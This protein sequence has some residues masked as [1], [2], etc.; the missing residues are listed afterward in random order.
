MKLGADFFKQDAL[1][2]APALLGKTIGRRLKDGQLIYGKITETEVYRGEVDTA[3]HARV[4]KT[5]RTKTLYDEGGV[6]YIYL[7]YG[8]HYLL[9]IVT[10]K[11]EEP[12][13]V[14]IRAIATANGPGKLTKALQIDL[15]MNGIQ[16]TNSDLI[17]ILD[18]NEQASYKTAPRIGIDYASEPYKSIKWRFIIDE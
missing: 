7:C 10:G 13:A 11:K 17:W 14:L 4:G 2:V 8:V 16:I 3:C 9:N 6:I 5:N 18:N 15:S 12:Q 1:V